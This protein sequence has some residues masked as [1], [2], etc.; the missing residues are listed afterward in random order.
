MG[1]TPKRRKFIAEFLDNG[2]NATQAAAD[3]G[4]SGN[5]Q[6][7][8]SIGYHLRHEVPEVRDRIE[9]Q[10]AVMLKTPEETLHFLGEVMGVDVGE[11]VTVRDGSIV[12]ED[13]DALRDAGLTRFVKEIRETKHGVVVKMYSKLDAAEKILRAGGAYTQRVEHAGSLEHEHTGTVTLDT[14]VRA[15]EAIAGEGD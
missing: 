11:I 15:K 6:T 4:Y 3:A 1:L 8:G 9:R 14:F 13:W 10:L 7:L 12:V 5:R 2:F